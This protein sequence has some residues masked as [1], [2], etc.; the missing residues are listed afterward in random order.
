MSQQIDYIAIK[1]L[2]PEFSGTAEAEGLA[3]GQ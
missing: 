3:P 2:V 1:H